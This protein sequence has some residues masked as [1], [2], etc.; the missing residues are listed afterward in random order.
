M[1]LT[2]SKKMSWHHSENLFWPAH[3][4]LVLCALLGNK[5]EDSGTPHI[6]KRIDIDK[7]LLKF[8]PQVRH[9]GVY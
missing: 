4:S 1:H 6:H 9:M 2:N 7:L 5:F 3:T 8:S